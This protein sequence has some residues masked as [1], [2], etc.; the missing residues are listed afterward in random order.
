ML[1]KCTL[2]Q[3]GVYDIM[4]NMKDYMVRVRI[5]YELYSRVKIHCIKK[6]LSFPKMTAQ[7]F[8]SLCETL[9][10]NE[11]YIKIEE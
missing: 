2:T 5:P 11:K 6:K 1:H 9:D 3:I 4:S 8:E 10:L 7:A